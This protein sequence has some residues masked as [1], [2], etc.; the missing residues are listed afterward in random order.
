MPTLKNIDPADAFMLLP[1]TPCRGGMPLP[2]WEAFVRRA[3]PVAF[4]AEEDGVSVGF[5]IAESHPKLVHVLYLEGTTAACRLLLDR[6][7][8]LAGERKMAGRFRAELPD[9]LAMLEVAGFKRLFED[10]FNGKPTFFCE[11]RTGDEEE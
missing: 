10:E 8:R 2:E 11:R 4:V 5:A 3:G 9:L 1:G 6:L 7:V